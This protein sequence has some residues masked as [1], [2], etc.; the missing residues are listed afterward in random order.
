MRTCPILVS[1]MRAGLGPSLVSERYRGW[2][3]PLDA[4]ATVESLLAEVPSKFLTNLGA[5]VLTN[6]DGLARGPRRTWSYNRKLA[7]KDCRGLYHRGQK[8]SLPWI[9]LFVDR[10]CDGVPLWALRIRLLREIFFADVLFHEVGHHIHP[11]QQRE[12]SDH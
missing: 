3:P 4:K 10:I 2:T 8:R 5:I 1:W 9:E 7:I 11:T 6:A 12:H